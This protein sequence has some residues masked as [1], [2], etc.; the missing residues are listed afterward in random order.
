M[1]IGMDMVARATLCPRHYGVCVSQI[2]A[3]W[4]HNNEQAVTDKFRRQIV[5]QQLIWLIRKGDVI[6]PDEPLVSTLSVE[7]RFTSRDI[8][9]NGDMRIIFVS[10][11]AN[12][13]PSDISN[14]PRG[15]VFLLYSTP[16]SQ[17]LGFYASHVQAQYIC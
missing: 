16:Y 11:T 2:Y 1:G 7:C 10:S 15:M 13:P 14:L 3:D 9:S 17:F 12:N 4:V 8:D 5:P 6:L